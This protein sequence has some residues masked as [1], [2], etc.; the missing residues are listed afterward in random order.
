MKTASAIS[1]M[2]VCLLTNGC[3]TVPTFTKIEMLAKQ[4]GAPFT[5]DANYLVLARYWDDNAEKQMIDSI[6]ASFLTIREE[7]GRA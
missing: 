3:I 5:I 2:V 6:G 7:E 1:L 4:S